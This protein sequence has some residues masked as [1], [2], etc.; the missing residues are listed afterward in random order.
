M[1]AI[2]LTNAAIAIAI[3]LTL[4]N[5]LQPG[6]SFTLAGSPALERRSIRIRA[7]GPGRSPPTGRS[8]S[9]RTWSSFLPTSLFR[10]LV[11]NADHHDR[12]PRR[13]G[14]RGASAGEDGAD[15]ARGD[16]IPGDR[17]RDRDDLSGDRGHPGLGDR[18]GTAG[19]LR[20]GR[21]DGR[22]SMASGRFGGCWSISRWACSGWRSRSWW[23]T[24]H[25]WCWSPGCRW[26]RFWSGA[27]D[28]IATAIGTGS[29]LATLP[30]TLRSLDRMG[31]SPR[32]AR[33]AA[34]VGTNLNNDGILLYEAMA[35]LF[36]AQAIGVEL[37]RRPAASR[38]GLVRDRR[39]RDLGVPDAGL[40][41]LLIVLK[42]V[43]PHEASGRL[44]R[45]VP[46]LG[47][48]GSGTL[49]V[50]DQRRQ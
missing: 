16:R 44:D 5:V 6:R 31:V 14:R 47:R 29:S 26:S 42:T 23:S 25:G 36:V 27:K 3:G 46:A 45:P 49:P 15:R 32:S 13:P 48:L 40:I 1:V 20:G 21:P 19:R 39:D 7:G 4:S 50:D 38:G 33:L 24:R 10:P 9:S 22:A 8:S 11:E 18:P 12:D 35:V 34:C 37:T 30:V 17:G 2:S 28:A 41:S 43:M